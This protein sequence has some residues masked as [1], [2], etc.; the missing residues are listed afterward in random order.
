M[1]S[2]YESDAEINAVVRGFESC[3]TDKADFKH[4]DHLTV[5]VCYVENST[6]ADANDKMRSG[7]LRFLDHH[8]VDQQKYN[9]TITSFWIQVVVLELRK[10]PLELSLV[11]KCNRVIDAFNNHSLILDYY[12]RELL[13]SDEARAVFVSPDLKEWRDIQS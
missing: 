7:L 3:K 9:E 2:F 13:F 8:Q 12:S 1:S 6:S 4:H 11:E 10:M 5:A